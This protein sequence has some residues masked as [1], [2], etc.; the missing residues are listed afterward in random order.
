MAH[1]TKAVRKATGAVPQ[2]GR[3]SRQ[4]PVAGRRARADVH[5][6]VL[7][8]RLS[9]DLG[10]PGRRHEGARDRARARGHR[11]RFGRVQRAL[12]SDRRSRRRHRGRPQR[13]PYRARQAQDLR[14]AKPAGLSD[15]LPLLRPRRRARQ[16]RRLRPAA[17]RQARPRDARLL[18][19]APRRSAA[20]ASASSPATSTATACSGISSA[21]ATRS[22]A[23][24]ASIRRSFSRPGRSRSSGRCTRSVWRRSSTNRSSAG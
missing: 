1:S 15:L 12:L 10:R 19:Q 2:G 8:A 3:A 9:P 22:P 23:C 20:G 13:R 24:T 11:H 5:A 7:E 18:G 4:A 14:A 16:R 21:R 17:A 6:R